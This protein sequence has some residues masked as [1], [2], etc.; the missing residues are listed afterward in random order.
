MPHTKTSL[1]G[2]GCSLFLASLGA[3][4]LILGSCQSQSEAHTSIDAGGNQTGSFP[5]SA[6]SG[7]GNSSEPATANDGVDMVGDTGA[8]DDG[9]EMLGDAGGFDRSGDAEAADNLAEGM[10]G[11][12]AKAIAAG[13][14]T[15][16]GDTNDGSDS[17]GDVG[18]ID[19]FVMSRGGT[20]IMDIS[21]G[22]SHTCALRQDGTIVCWGD[23]E[24]GKAVAPGGAFSQVSAGPDA[25]CAITKGDGNVVCW[26]AQ[27][28][29]QVPVGS[30]TQ[31]GVGRRHACAIREDGSVQCWGVYS[32]VRVY[33]GAPLPL[34][35]A[36]RLI[37][38]SH[39]QVSVGENH[40]CALN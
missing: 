25:T 15:A 18:E 17:E 12:D 20:G 1:S 6:G 27:E 21:I 32:N 34:P 36:A 13:D 14:A 24:Y 11:G 28:V 37:S 22:R 38:G 19:P 9:P 30:Y 39:R 2:R 5:V 8:T 29:T 40:A 4:C 7:G 23:N 35:S 33:P 3:G 26:G 31:V 16:V 10:D